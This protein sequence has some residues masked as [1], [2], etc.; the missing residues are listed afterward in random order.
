MDYPPPVLADDTN[1]TQET[2][3]ADNGAIAE[4]A[5][6]NPMPLLAWVAI[7]GGAVIVGGSAAVFAVKRKG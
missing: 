7:I 5:K 2:E 4:P 3:N 1:N 6:E